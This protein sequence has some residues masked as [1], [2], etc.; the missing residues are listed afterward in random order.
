MS[1]R[2]LTLVWRESDAHAD[3][4]L[5]GGDGAG[6]GPVAWAGRHTFERAQAEAEAK[7][8]ARAVRR[9]VRGRGSEA[10]VASGRLLF[11]L[12]LPGP[13]KAALRGPAGS[14]TVVGGGWPWAL[15]HDGI[16]PL[17]LRWALGELGL[18]GAPLGDG[19]PE[20]DG[21]RLLVVA[22]PAADLP[23]AR[24]EGEALMREMAGGAGCDLRLGRLRRQDFLR[25][26]RGYRLVHFAGH[27][28][29]ADDDGPAGWRLS[30]GRVDAEALRTLAGGSAPALVFANACRSAQAPAVGDALLA[31]GVRHFIGTTVDLPDLPG[32]DFATRF[33]RALRE[34]LAVGEALRRARVADAEAGQAVWAAYRLRGD[35]GTVYFRARAA[36]RW[37]PGVRQAVLLAVRRPHAVPGRGPPVE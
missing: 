2:T 36:E 14:L 37:A 4:V 23:A 20:V 30:D 8:I 5:L 17:G 11:D 26:F 16:A 21:E 25:I 18:D 7:A 15:L 32:A 3:V 9:A 34:G 13:V 33:Y 1:S 10:L 24:Y 35:P 12:L 6:A 19:R 29:P 22:D 28:D 27:A 31:G